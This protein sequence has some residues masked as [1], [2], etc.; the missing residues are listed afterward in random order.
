MTS[1]T[2]NNQ[3]P[4]ILD[5]FHIRILP[6]FAWVMSYNLTFPASHNLSSILER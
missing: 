2:K 5:D 1:S 3:F 6:H 4:F